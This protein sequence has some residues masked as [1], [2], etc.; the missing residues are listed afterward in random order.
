M[1]RAPAMHEAEAC[2]LANELGDDRLSCL[3]RATRHSHNL[4]RN[5]VSIVEDLSDAAERVHQSRPMPSAILVQRCKILRSLRVHALLAA[6]K[7]I[8]ELVE[9][10]GAQRGLSLGHDR[11]LPTI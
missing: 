7:P 6:T 9:L 10:A 11:V 4:R 2:S 8:A 1:I 3:Q 5:P